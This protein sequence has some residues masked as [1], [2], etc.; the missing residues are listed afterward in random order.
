MPTMGWTIG[1][2][3]AAYMD[4]QADP[5]TLL[6]ALLAGLQRDDPAW[7]MIV[8]SAALKQQLDALADALERV[9]GERSRLPLYGIPFAVK[10]NM[11]VAGLATTAACPAFSHVAEQDAA[12]VARLRAAG[13]VIVGKT[14]LDQ[15]ATGLVG[16]RSPYGVVTN[17]FNPA[18]IGGGSSSGSASVVARGI[19]PFALG[20]DTAGSGRVPAAFNNLVGLK[21]TRG[22]V[23]SVGVVPACRTLDCVSVFA[24][25]AEDAGSVLDV[26]AG[27]DAA[28]PYSRPCPPDQAAVRIG[29]TPR[30]AIPQQPDFC[31]DVVQAAAYSVALA[32]MRALGV[33]LEPVDFGPMQALAALL[34][35][36]PWVAE[37]Y[38]AIAEFMADHAADMHPVVRDII[39]R[40]GRYSAIDAFKAEYRR[41]ELKR[42]LDSLLADFDALLVPSA[43]TLPTLAAVAAE[44]I[45]AN[46]QLGIYTNFVNL[47]D[48]AALAL[49]AGWR[50]DGL[51]FGVTLIAPA[52]RDHALLDFARRWQRHAPWKLGATGLDLPAE[53]AAPAVPAPAPGYIRLAVVGAHLTGMPLNHQLTTRHAQF[54]ERTR[55]ADCYRLYALPNTA[56]PKPGLVRDAQNGSAI[57]VEVWDVP[58]AGFGSFVAEVPAPLG[59]GS[60]ELREGSVV[61]G[62]ICEPCALQG[63]TEITALGGWRAFLAQLNNPGKSI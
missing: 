43:P 52:W 10:D 9:N 30:F 34:Y 12:V 6:Q 1:Q 3:R 13:A 44:P 42:A 48:C 26:I 23:S 16:V 47:G 32:Q 61:K 15:F 59:I 60:V 20:T 56:P 4:T 55:T 25:S 27:F 28:D 31:G 8:D 36:G 29:Q 57:E 53:R 21:P 38:A 7:I 39:E 35:D 11:D 46:S 37:R 33:V 41:A 22:L 54:V 45:A 58:L 62:F 49:P 40:A 19:V 51:P 2:W 18:Y 24:L 17:P 63:A 14:N 50:S 5:G